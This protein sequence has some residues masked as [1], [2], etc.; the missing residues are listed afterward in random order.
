LHK[1]PR[2]IARWATALEEYSF[3]IKGVCQVAHNLARH[4]GKQQTLDHVKEDYV[5]PRMPKFVQDYVQ[6]CTI[7]QENKINRHPSNPGLSPLELAEWP[8][9][10]I[11][12][13]FVND[14]PTSEGFD[15]ILTIVDQGLTKAIMLVPCKKM[16]DVNG[17]VKALIKNMF[18]KFGLPDK[19]VLDWGLQ[20]ASQVFQQVTE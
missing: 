10:H 3:I 7:C 18:L 2:T 20:F 8:F 15:S 6:G 9:Q 5:C 1:I 19:I 13:D 16:I 12:M 11:T 4:P 17:P 14:L